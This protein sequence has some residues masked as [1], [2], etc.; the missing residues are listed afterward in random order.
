MKLTTIGPMPVPAS[1]A[2]S[3]APIAAPLLP[4]SVEP[5]SSVMPVIVH[6][7]SGDVPMPRIRQATDNVAASLA[8][9]II[10]TATRINARAPVIVQRYPMRSITQPNGLRKRLSPK[11]CSAKEKP[12]TV[13]DRPRM[14]SI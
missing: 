5:A 11:Y 7:Q 2:I 10:P 3:T 9:I 6:G 4:L 13:T 14:F 8:Y 12:T 1:E